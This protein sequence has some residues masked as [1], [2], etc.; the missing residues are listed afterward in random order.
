MPPHQA[1]YGL[2][3]AP[4]TW[5]AR[6]N[7]V[8]TTAG[9]TP[10][11]ADASL[12]THTTDE[13]FMLVYVD[14]ILILAKDAPTASKHKASL[15]AAFDARDLGPASFYLGIKITRNRAAKTI[16][17]SHE[18]MIYDLA[19]K[20][21]LTDA[22]PRDIPMSLGMRLSKA[23][24]DPLDTKAYPYSSLV[25]ALNYIAVTTRP[26]ISFVVGGLSRFMARPTTTH[27]GM[28]KAVL[29]YLAGT[30]TLGITFAGAKPFFLAY[31]D[32][33]YAADPDTRRSTTGYLFV[34]NGGAVTWSSKRQPTVAASTTEA[35]YIAAAAATKEALWVRKLLASFKADPGTVEIFS[36]NQG[37]IKLIRNPVITPRSKHIDVAHHFTRERA[38]RGEVTFTYVPTDK[39][40]ADALTKALPLGKFEGYRASMGMA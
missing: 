8:L 21:D 38:A 15:M 20:Y 2:K 23:D 24:G 14:D 31:C 19:A 32:S 18:K 4:R 26:D 37:T 17:M 16:K 5:H 35:E 36:D 33:D 9:F 39:N 29:R 6:L 22:K 7:G 27:W 3:Q 30:A 25:G 10:T 34:L 1:L 13:A 11:D 28:A 12:Y 40:P